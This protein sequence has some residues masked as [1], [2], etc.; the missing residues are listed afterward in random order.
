VQV[1]GTGSSINTCSSQQ[2]VLNVLYSTA[3]WTVDSQNYIVG[4]ELTTL[5]SSDS[6]WNRKYLRVNWIYV[7]PSVISNPPENKFYQY[8]SYIWKPLREYFGVY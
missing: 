2:I 8:F 3:G 5:A 6:S 7:D 1:S 4:A